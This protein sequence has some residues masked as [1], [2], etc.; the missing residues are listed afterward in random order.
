MSVWRITRCPWQGE[1]LLRPRV[2]PAVL[3]A[4][5]A[6]TLPECRSGSS[7]RWRG[8]AAPGSCAGP[9]RPPA[10]GWRTSVAG[11][12]AR[13]RRRARRCAARARSRRRTSEGDSRRPRL[14][15]EQRGLRG[16]RS[17]PSGGRP[18]GEVALERALGGLA[19]RH[20]AGLGAL[21][22]HPQLLG[23]EVE[24]RRGRG[25]RSPR[26]AGRTSRRARAS[27]GRAASSGVRAGIRS[28]SCAS[29]S[30]AQQPAA[31]C[32]AA[33]GEGTRSAGFWS[34]SPRSTMCR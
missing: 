25:S 24:R 20:D 13:A 17:G 19:D 6:L 28:S 23:V 27:R 3:A 32:A 16:L 31:G 2:A 7:R 26:S 18:V 4:Q 22:E 1:R 8:P 5:P 29:S 21:A 15:E 30:A 9:P 34:S 14:R 10:G 11:R 33:R 12:A